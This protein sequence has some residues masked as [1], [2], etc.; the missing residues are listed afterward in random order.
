[1]QRPTC[2]GVLIGM[3]AEGTPFLGIAL[4]VAVSLSPLAIHRTSG[5][6]HTTGAK[7]D[8]AAAAVQAV[9]DA[10]AAKDQLD[11]LMRELD[12]L[13]KMSKDAASAID[14]A[15]SDADRAAAEARLE[16]LRHE[17][18]ELTKRATDSRALAHR[19]RAPCR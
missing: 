4:A 2:G 7:R 5:S 16:Q 12:E 17:Q 1:M 3:Q 15:E 8:D 11:Q 18:Y 9:K 14:V 19:G 6:G 10:Q 13:D